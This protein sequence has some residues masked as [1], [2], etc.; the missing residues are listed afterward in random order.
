MANANSL[1]YHKAKV[2]N[3]YDYKGKLKNN[4]PKQSQTCNNGQL[5]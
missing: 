1:I 3:E 2:Y 5:S 4:I